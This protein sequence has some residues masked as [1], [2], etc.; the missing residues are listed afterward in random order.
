M[1]KIIFFI[2]FSIAVISTKAQGDYIKIIVP[3]AL[4]YSGDV[5]APHFVD[6]TTLIATK[7]VNGKESLVKYRYGGKRFDELGTLSSNAATGGSVNGKP[8]YYLSQG[9]VLPIMESDTL[10]NT[11]QDEVWVM[12]SDEHLFVVVQNEDLDI[13]TVRKSG[14]VWKYDKSWDFCET[15]RDE[16]DLFIFADTL[17][18]SARDSLGFYQLYKSIWRAPIAGDEDNEGFWTTPKKMPS[19]YNKANCHNMFYI[20]DHDGIEYISSDRKDKNMQIYAIGYKYQLKRKIYFNTY[21]TN[22]TP[23]NYAFYNDTLSLVDGLHRSS[24]NLIKEKSYD[25]TINPDGYM[26]NR[27]NFDLVPDSTRR[28]E[29]NKIDLTDET[30]YAN[31]EFTE[32]EIRY[33]FGMYK[34][35]LLYNQIG[36]YSIGRNPDFHGWFPGYNVRSWTKTQRTKRWLIWN[37]DLEKALETLRHVKSVF[38][39]KNVSDNPFIF[40][41]LEDS[42]GND[43]GFDVVTIGNDDKFQIRYHP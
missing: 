42:E 27:T 32:K 12:G 4:D 15:N 24:E 35:K 33:I 21:E 11:M 7:N 6:D 18:F 13:C 23:D 26:F 1:R 22:V 31:Q 40:I 39:S 37:T 20:Q 9:D 36:I 30:T 34:I 43:V 5:Y 10:F 2:S 3:L 25:M 14:G 19:P 38:T 41:M 17:V 8:Y 29:L 28:E 16:H